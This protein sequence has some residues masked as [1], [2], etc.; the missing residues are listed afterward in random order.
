MQNGMI[1]SM[2]LNQKSFHGKGYVIEKLGDFNFKISPKS[3][4]QTNTKQAEN[5]IQCCKKFCCA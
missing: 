4:F 3:F 1:A 2:T 5:L